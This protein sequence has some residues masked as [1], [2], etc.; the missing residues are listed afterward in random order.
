MTQRDDKG[1][2]D[3]KIEEIKTRIREYPDFPKPGITFRD[4][5]PLFHHPSLQHTIV[6]LLKGQIDEK[7]SN[8]K[9]DM[10][11]GIDSRGFLFGPEL[12]NALGC[13]FIPARKKGKLP[14]ATVT[15][16]YQLEYGSDTL[17][18][19]KEYVVAGKCAI[20]VDDLIATG[21]TMAAAYNLLTNSGVEVLECQCLV[22][23]PE[24]HGRDKL[25][26]QCPVFC[27]VEYGGC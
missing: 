18:M 8:R 2:R 25:P 21:G 6:E 27:L 1:S 13:N 10:I 9:I 14:G 19:Q 24:L 17:E 7:Y 20:I 12:A 16:S 26:K 11:V 23:L 22:E 4:V 5:F 15:Q 3:E